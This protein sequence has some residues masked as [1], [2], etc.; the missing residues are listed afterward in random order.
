[1]TDYSDII[2]LMGAMIVFSLLT[3]QTNR[4]FQ[5]NNRMQINGE[6]KYNAISIA[7]DQLE[8]VQWIHSKSE[9]N[10]YI[11][12]FPKVI[13]TPIGNGSMNYN[14]DLKSSDITIP[15]SNVDTKRIEVSVTNK[16]L[17]QNS[18]GN[19]AIKLQLLKSFN[20]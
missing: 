3:I 13:S 11:N 10:S 14:V 17:K 16:Y 20:S 1:M 4:A 9:L 8:K 12:S 5:L 15:D 6:I 2:L 7:Q 18:S 19:E